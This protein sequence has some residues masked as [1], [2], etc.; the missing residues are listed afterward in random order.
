MTDE[1]SW[2]IVAYRTASS[3]ARSMLS[4]GI[5]TKEEYRKIDTILLKKYG[6][7]S[8]SIFR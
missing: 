7:S 5:I 4:Q 2:R 8:C 1:L 3:I 6:L